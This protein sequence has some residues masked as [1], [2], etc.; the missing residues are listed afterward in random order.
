[1]R[2]S[3][4][5]LWTQGALARSQAARKGTAVE[6]NE[7]HPDPLAQGMSAAGQKVAEAAAI[8]ALVMQVLMQVRARRTSQEATETAADEAGHAAAQAL[9]A[10]A[11][12]PEWLADAGLPDTARAWSAAAVWEH[13]DPSAA[14]AADAAESRLRD[15]HPYAMRRYDELR[16]QGASRA[17]AMT[18]TVPLFAMHPNP[19]PAP[20][21][22][23]QG[24]YLASAPGAGRG[25]PGHAGNGH[26]RGGPR[27]G[28]PGPAERRVGQPGR[29]AADPRRGRD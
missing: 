16:G 26:R 29:W 9:W 2:R 11:L 19:R 14:A 24:R 5:S 3:K 23:W 20:R 13:A 4:G 10:P 18:D 22:V 7:T 17:A 27:P 12:H 1:M 21:D 28:H 8:L 6:P 25:A 15:L